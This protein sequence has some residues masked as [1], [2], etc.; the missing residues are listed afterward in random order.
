MKKKKID[1]NNKKSVDKIINSKQIIKEEKKKI[2]LE[3]KNIR[4]RKIDKMKNTRLGKILFFLSDGKERY[5]FSEVFVTTIVSLILGAFV[6]MSIFSIVFGGR[7]YFKM[8]SKFGKIYD[9]YEALIEN[10][11]GEIDDEKLMDEAISGMVA[12]VGDVYTRYSDTESTEDFDQMVTGTYEG[13]G[14]TILQQTDKITVVDV[15]D[16]TPANKAG[17]KSGD[18]IKSVDGKDALELGAD[19]LSNYIK[20]DATGKI[21][22]VVVRDDK[23]ITLSLTRSKIEVPTVISK[24]FQE[25]GKNI[26]YINI[27]LFSSITTKQFEN[28]LKKLDKEKIEGLVIDVRGNNGGYLSTVNEIASML[29][30]KGKVIYQIKKGDE[31]TSVKDR[32]SDYKKYPIAVLTDGGSASASEILAAAIKESYNGFVV[33]TKTFGKGTVQQVKKLS[34]GSMIKYTTQDWLT[35][36]GEWINEVGIEPTHEVIM[37][38]EYYANPVLENDNQLQK[39][40]ELVSE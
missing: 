39:A 21:K 22:M 14:C 35:P 3:K 4:K 8:A 6:C 16:D 32:T 28:A 20:N 17:L 29:L 5:S 2:K 31:K 11:N 30:P 24:V 9:V 36:S 25:N 19:A 13:I 40:L 12:S 38:E 18:I 26:G 33:G 23:E 1:E 37:N 7:N 34:D 10:Y 27:S 15:Y